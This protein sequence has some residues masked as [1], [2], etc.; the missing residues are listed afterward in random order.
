MPATMPVAVKP[1]SFKL[2]VSMAAC[3]DGG[4]KLKASP[5]Y[6]NACI[7]SNIQP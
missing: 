3:A 2:A 5:P 4:R 7:A 6:I 1:A